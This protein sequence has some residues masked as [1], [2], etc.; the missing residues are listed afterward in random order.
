A[1][2]WLGPVASICVLYGAVVMLERRRIPW[3]AVSVAALLILFLQVGKNQFRTVYWGE[4]ADAT[5]SERVGFW[6]GESASR[7]DSALQGDRGYTPQIL[8]AQTLQRLSLLPQVAHV[9]ELTPSQVPFQEGATYQYLGV[10]FIPRFLWPDKP[11]V[12]EANRF[13]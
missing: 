4:R 2:G 7:W 5:L 11:S 8:A 12:N 3:L 1:S 6:L 9:V 13:Y 10:T